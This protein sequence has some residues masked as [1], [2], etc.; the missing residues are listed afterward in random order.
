M[1]DHSIR[2]TSQQGPCLAVLFGHRQHHLQM[3]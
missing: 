1:N 2:S 3:V